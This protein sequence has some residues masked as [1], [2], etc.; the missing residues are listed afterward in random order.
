MNEKQFMSAMKHIT[1]LTLPEG[2]TD[3]PASSACRSCV[4]TRLTCFC[5]PE[6]R[7]ARVR[8]PRVAPG[9]RDRSCSITQLD[10]QLFH[11]GP[12]GLCDLLSRGSGA[13]LFTCKNKSNKQRFF[14]CTETCMPVLHTLYVEQS[15]QNNSSTTPKRQNILCSCSYLLCL[16][17]IAP[18]LVAMKMPFSFM[19]AFLLSCVALTV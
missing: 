2:Q 6:Q 11:E 17:T 10:C 18:P 7:S 14:A 16:R 5:Q 15:L 1:R 12:V 19:G 9:R 8:G 3:W 4:N 13:G